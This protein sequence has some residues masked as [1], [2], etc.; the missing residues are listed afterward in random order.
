L[1]AIG[2][3]IGAVIGILGMI[4]NLAIAR[5][6]PSVGLRAVVMIGVVVVCYVVIFIIAGLLYAATHPT[7]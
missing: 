3:L 7:T 6:V 4:S 5:R 2:G 1:V